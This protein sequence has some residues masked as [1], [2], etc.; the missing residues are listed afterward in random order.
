MEKELKNKL[1]T[2]PAGAPLPLGGGGGVLVELGPLAGDG[3]EGTDGE[4]EGTDGEPGLGVPEDGGGVVVEEGDGDG[5]DFGVFEGPGAAVFGAGAG[6][7]GEGAGDLVGGVVVGAGEGAVVVVPVAVMVSFWP[8]EQCPAM[9][10][11]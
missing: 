2:A 10:Q 8:A 6:A 5:A 9:V 7:F 3:D 11:M 1:A 4:P